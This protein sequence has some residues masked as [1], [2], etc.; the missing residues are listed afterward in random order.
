MVHTNSDKGCYNLL[1]MFTEWRPEDLG[2]QLTARHMLE[3]YG[4]MLCPRPIK[5]GKAKN[6][7]ITRL[8]LKD[9]FTSTAR[10]GPSA[11]P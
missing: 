7:W 8:V 10:F 9:S 11:T 1:Q 4:F 5:L 6:L 3:Q 2:C